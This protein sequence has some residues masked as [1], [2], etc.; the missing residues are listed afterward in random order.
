MIAH[1]TRNA[2]VLPDAQSL[3]P[4]PALPDPLPQLFP[5]D[6]LARGFGG[7]DDSDATC[8]HLRGAGQDGEQQVFGEI[9]PGPGKPGGPWEEFAV[10]I[11]LHDGLVG[12]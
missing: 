5:S 9:H 4:A 8:F 11:V 1:I 7:S 3:Q 12:C 10:A 6:L 2:I